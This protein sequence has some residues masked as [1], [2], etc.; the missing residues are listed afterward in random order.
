MTNAKFLMVF[1]VVIVSALDVE[2]GQYLDKK[3]KGD[4]YAQDDLT[5]YYY[6]RHVGTHMNNFHYQSP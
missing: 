4:R 5:Y 6:C 2:Q 3:M 1:L